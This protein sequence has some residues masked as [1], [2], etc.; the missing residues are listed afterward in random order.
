[1]AQNSACLLE[2]SHP[3]LDRASLVLD[4][5]TQEELGAVITYSR[6]LLDSLVSIVPVNN[7]Y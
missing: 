4:E 2:F 5:D 7:I 6:Y 1:M 3:A